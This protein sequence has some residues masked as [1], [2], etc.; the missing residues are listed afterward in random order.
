M[1]V[2]QSS[3]DSGIPFP[4]SRF[5]PAGKIDSLK[6]QSPPFAGAEIPASFTLR[7]LRL[8]G[9]R[10]TLGGRKNHCRLGVSA[11]LPAIKRVV[12]LV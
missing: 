12:D 7:K 3:A 6:A 4:E 2:S 9:P 10:Q 8:S 5:R 1:A 11:K